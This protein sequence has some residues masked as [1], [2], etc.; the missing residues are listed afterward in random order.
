MHRLTS[1]TQARHMFGIGQVELQDLGVAVVG[2]DFSDLQIDKTLVAAGESLCHGKGSF[3]IFSWLG[4]I[5]GGLLVVS[6]E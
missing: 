3:C 1:Y 5:G 4:S 2:D 6:Q